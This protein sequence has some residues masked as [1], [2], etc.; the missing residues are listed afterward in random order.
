MAKDHN[1]KMSQSNA[2]ARTHT[3]PLAPFI[4]LLA[5]ESSLHVCVCVCVLTEWLMHCALFTDER[6]SVPVSS[7]AFTSLSASNK[8]LTP[9]IHA[10]FF[11]FFLVTLALL[12][13]RQ[14]FYKKMISINATPYFLFTLSSSPL[15]AHFIHYTHTRPAMKTHAY[16]PPIIM[17]LVAFILKLEG[18]YIFTAVSTQG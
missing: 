2:H 9:L 10:R 12:L 7:S 5:S 6:L 11:F 8:H 16:L 17:P 14:D 4:H 3:L 15:A 18:S 1:A 13:H